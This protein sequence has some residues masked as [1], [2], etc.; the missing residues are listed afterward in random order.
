MRFTDIEGVL[1][2]P[3]HLMSNISL[4]KH[5]LKEPKTAKQLMQAL[6][7]S[8]QSLY[9]LLNA[10][11]Q[12]IL[13]IGKARAMRYAHKRP[14]RNLGQ[15]WPVYRV[16]EQADV[17]LAGQLVAIYPHHFVWRDALTVSDTIY[18]SLPWFL[19]DVRPQG[20]MGR[21]F[22]QE[23]Q[24][25]SLPVRLED[26]S[27]DDV[28]AALL[29]DSSVLA[30]HWLIGEASHID[31]D[32]ERQWVLSLISGDR[33]SLRTTYL[34]HV[35]STIKQEAPTSTAAGM[36]PKFGLLI[37]EK[38]QVVELLIKFSPPINTANGQRWSDLLISEHIALQTLKSYGV[39][40]AESDIVQTGGRT[41]LEVVRFDRAS[42]LGRRG[43]VSLEAVS[44][45]FIGHKK[46]WDE[47]ASSLLALKKISQ[48][49]YQT[50][51]QVF[52]FGRLIANEDMHNG[53]VS[54]FLANDFSLSLAPVYDM[55]PMRFA[56]TTHG[57]VV[58]RAIKIAQPTPLTQVI[59]PMAWRWAKTYWQKVSNDVR[60]SE[61]FR[62]I[63]QQ[64]VANI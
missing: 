46:D 53:N 7:I 58:E 54:F 11:H 10:S 59:W 55:L 4:E 28:M 39:A 52:A 29:R 42:C 17:H 50:I 15:E 13:K 38:N 41:F 25:L 9:R 3:R 12:K 51:I 40:T 43:M 35:N 18:D 64:Y 63:A 49:D 31:F 20:F 33:A 26:W 45:E 19:W 56:P 8:P 48:H 24:D 34:F 36:Q 30:S 57:E 16:N 21:A 47:Q 1:I 23:H 5:L 61:S 60:I 6:Q 27:D 22:N 14:I 32:H 62:A 44:N 37:K 2:E